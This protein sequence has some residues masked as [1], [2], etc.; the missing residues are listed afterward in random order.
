[1]ESV[2]FFVDCDDTNFLYQEMITL[3]FFVEH[4][5]HKLI[6]NEYDNGISVVIINKI[7]R[8]II[9]KQM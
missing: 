9:T 3:I 2:F 6:A 8:K 5:Y 1:M 4:D 7:K